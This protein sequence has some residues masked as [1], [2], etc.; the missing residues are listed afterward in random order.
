[1]VHVFQVFGKDGLYYV[2]RPDISKIVYLDPLPPNSL[3]NHPDFNRMVIQVLDIGHYHGLPSI[4]VADVKK[5]NPTVLVIG[6]CWSSQ[7]DAALAL[8]GEA[9]FSRMILQ[10]DIRA[11][12]GVETAEL[13]DQQ[14]E[15]VQKMIEN[16]VHLLCLSGYSGSGKT[17][18]AGEYLKCMAAKLIRE[19]G[20]VTLDIFVCVMITRGVDKGTSS[21]HQHVVH[22]CGG[23]RLWYLSSSLGFF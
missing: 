3:R 17:Y 4:F 9:V 1:M 21:Q 5:F 11:I 14:K 10:H 13:S 7:G 12:S 8:R 22:P 16:V 18:I 15:I 20:A 2:A 19:N 6:W 23:T